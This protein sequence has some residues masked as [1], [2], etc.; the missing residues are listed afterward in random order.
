MLKKVINAILFLPLV[1][2]NNSLEIKANEKQGFIDK[3]LEEKSNKPFISY[4]EIEKIIL[5]NQELKSLKNLVASA[6]F[7]LSSQIAQRYPSLDFQANGLP[8]YVAG[9]NKNSNSTT[10]KTSQFSANPS[11]N[12]KW[13]LIDPLRGSEIKIA[14]DNYKIAENNYEIKKKDLIQEAKIRYHKYE[15]SFQDIENKK[16]ALDLSNTSLNNAKAKLESGIGTKFEVLEAEAQLSRDKQLL[17]EKKIE[18]KIGFITF[19]SIF[20]VI[21]FIRFANQS[22]Y[23]IIRII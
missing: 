4:Q 7:N 11:L 14:R 20:Y 18:N 13:D 2:F 1:L 8:K 17:N 5:N 15:K 22:I 10:L 9:K 3:V 19:L 12:I 21:C 23:N 6:S 16:F